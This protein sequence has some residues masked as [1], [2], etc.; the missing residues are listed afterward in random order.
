[1]ITDLFLE[2]QSGEFDVRSIRDFIEAL[3]FVV[4]CTKQPFSFM[5]VEDKDM[6]DDAIADRQRDDRRFP[7]PVLLIDVHP[8]RIDMSYRLS[9]LESGRIFVAWL[10]DHYAIRIRDEDYNDVTAQLDPNL[11]LIFGPK[12]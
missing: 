4:R 1:M 6:L 2:P 10:R 5:V 8:K 9:P 3:P 7:A 12:P 11:D